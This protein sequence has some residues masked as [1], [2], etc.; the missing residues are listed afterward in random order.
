[1][2]PPRSDINSDYNINNQR[3]PMN[4]LELV[5]DQIDNVDQTGFVKKV[6]GIFTTQI[7]FTTV[8]VGFAMMNPW[9]TAW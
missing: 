2:S 7:L 9:I 5:N 8:F 1:M 6:Y 4:D 3:V